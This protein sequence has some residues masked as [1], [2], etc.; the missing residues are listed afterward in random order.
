MNEK[1]VGKES[2]LYQVSSEQKIER[3]AGTYHL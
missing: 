2:P 3:V 1:E